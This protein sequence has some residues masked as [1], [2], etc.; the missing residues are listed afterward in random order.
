MERT[1]VTL[2]ELVGHLGE[3]IEHLLGGAPCIGRN[4]Y[5]GDQAPF[6]TR[7]SDHKKLIEVARKD[8]QE[9]HSL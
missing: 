1:G 2:L 5:A 7:D 8:G 6:E 9:I 3:V 4:G